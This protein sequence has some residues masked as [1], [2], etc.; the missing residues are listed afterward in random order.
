[1]GFR[2]LDQRVMKKIL[3]T[4]P[5]GI[6]SQIETLC[7]EIAP[8]Q[9][10]TFVE[11][12]PPPN[13]LPRECFFK[14][15]RQVERE[16]GRLLFGWAIWEWPGVFI[17]AEHHSIWD[18]GDALIDITPHECPTNGVLFLPDP[19]AQYD[20]EHHT[21]RDNFRRALTDAPAVQDWLDASERFQRRL[22]ASSV[23]R[24]YRLSPS[25]QREIAALASEVEESKA[26]V[27]FHLANNLSVNSPCFCRSGKKFKNAAPPILD[28][29]CQGRYFRSGFAARS[30]CFCASAGVQPLEAP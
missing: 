6:T 23:G 10:P 5:A 29:R 8:D 17:E 2:E 1:M 9:R 25:D 16:G 20:F 13:A 21:R 18:S 3:A 30:T 12:R 15:A 27:Y 24:E 4:T 26:E 19:S 22:E 7:H 11:H 14:V 28:S